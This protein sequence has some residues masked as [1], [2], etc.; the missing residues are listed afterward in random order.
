MTIH[1][2]G[3][4]IVAIC[5]LVL[6]AINLLVFYLI[7]NTIVTWVLGVPSFLFLLFIIRFFRKP[8]RSLIID[9]NTI[10]APADGTVLVIEETEETEYF[11]D[12]RIQ[13]SIFMSV[14]NIHINW[15]PIS[16]IIKYFKYHPGKFL[17][18]RL[19]KSSTE[20]ERTTV[21]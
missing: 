16:G 9:E 15:F 19:P 6:L 1:K 4:S 7:S 3:R 10:Y 21:V 11:K 13:I 8:K 5:F 18:A 14:W 12:K 2:E 20:N 17:I